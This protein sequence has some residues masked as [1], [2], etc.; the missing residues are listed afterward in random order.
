MGVTAKLRAN[1]SG[2]FP[3][4]VKK[5]FQGEGVAC[6]KRLGDVNELVSEHFGRAFAYD[7]I[8]TQLEKLAGPQMPGWIGAIGSHGRF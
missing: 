2:V 8:G 5:V 3:D 4:Q 1:K 7:E 6:P